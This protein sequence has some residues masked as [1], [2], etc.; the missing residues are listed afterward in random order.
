[1]PVLRRLAH[2]P[3]GASPELNRQSVSY[4]TIEKKSHGL[5]RPVIEMT[6]D[7]IAEMPVLG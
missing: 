6:R 4:S 1:M 2:H 5:L 3:R 7:G